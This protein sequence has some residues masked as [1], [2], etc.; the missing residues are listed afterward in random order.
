MTSSGP[1]R[2]TPGQPAALPGPTTSWPGQSVTSWVHP[3]RHRV[4]SVTPRAPSR[5]Q[6]LKV[7]ALD[8][9]AR[10]HGDA[11]LNQDPPAAVVALRVVVDRDRSASVGEYC[12]TPFCSISCQ[13]GTTAFLPDVVSLAT[14][15]SSSSCAQ[16]FEKNV[17]L[18]ITI[19]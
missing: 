9:G 10:L 13:I 4:N 12:A 8:G 14:S 1:P 7:V 5:H 2:T 16:A 17:G 3:E 19:P 18:R 15:P 11:G 6:D